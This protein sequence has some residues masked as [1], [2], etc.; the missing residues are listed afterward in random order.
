M[1]LGGDFGQRIVLTYGYPSDFASRVAVPRSL[2][3]RASDCLREYSRTLEELLPPI[4]SSELWIV[5]VFTQDVRWPPQ[6]A[7]HE[8]PRCTK[9]RSF[10]VV[11]R[12]KTFTEA[13]LF[14][15]DLITATGYSRSALNSIKVEREM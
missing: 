5:I 8:I 15:D 4:T 10:R 14:A 13:C 12:S 11:L 3:V 2:E 9:S 7:R 6:G 1:S